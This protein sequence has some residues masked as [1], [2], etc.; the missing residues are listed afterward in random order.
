[1]GGP[2]IPMHPCIFQPR[3]SCKT[4]SA[5]RKRLENGTARG[6]RFDAFRTGAEVTEAT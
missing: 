5:A 2:V 3:V 4:T 6:Y 1:M